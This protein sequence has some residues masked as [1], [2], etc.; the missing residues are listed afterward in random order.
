MKLP[1][2]VGVQGWRYPGEVDIPVPLFLN[3]LEESSA[4][5]SDGLPLPTSSLR[6]NMF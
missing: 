5:V 1:L 4:F 3:E 6:L 2:R